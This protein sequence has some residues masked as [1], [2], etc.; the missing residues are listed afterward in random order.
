L[1][2]LALDSLTLTDTQPVELIGVA[3]E[4]GFDIISLWVQ[5]PPLYPAPLLTAQ[6]EAECA[7]AL[8]D[9]DLTVVALEAFD[10]HSLAVVE[11]YREA[12][13][14]GAR[15]GAQNALAINYSNPDRAE[16]A[17]VLAKFA[18]IAAEYGLAVNLEPVAGGHTATLKQGADMIA[19]SGANVGITFDPW[20]LIGSGG[21]VADIL[22]IDRS[23]I[24]YVQLCDG[25]VPMP[26][27]TVGFGSVA[28]RAYPGDGQFPL[29]DMLRLLPLDVPIGF[30]CPS[31]SRVQAGRTPLEQAQEGIAAV[32][33]TL[34]LLD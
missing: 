10:L 18:E 13:E 29:L 26:A 32:R 23:L 20:H 4:A 17:A 6:K 25:P 1:P 16:T 7:R 21:S 11:T 19:A 2:R 33:R 15:L 8:A 5:A 27:E 28:E 31:V 22:E 14:R 34:A 24:R 12:L 3:Q 30:E 9:T